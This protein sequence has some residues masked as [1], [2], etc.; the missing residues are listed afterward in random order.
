VTSPGL[1]ISG[2]TRQ[3]QNEPQTDRALCERDRNP[4]TLAEHEWQ[5]SQRGPS[6]GQ[7]T[8]RPGRGPKIERRK[9]SCALESKMENEVLCRCQSENARTRSGRWPLLLLKLGLENESAVDETNQHQLVR[10]L[11]WPLK[12]VKHICSARKKQDRQIQTERKYSD[13][14]PAQNQ[15]VK[16]DFFSLNSNQIHATTDVIA[17]V[18]SSFN[19]RNKN[20][21][22]ANS[23]KSRKWK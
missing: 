10:F 15:D 3:E 8:G 13:L 5:N 12:S 6:R 22:L 21:F 16:T 7:R 11:V 23:L 1:E 20:L 4:A 19:Y 14:Q 17:L 2:K 9:S 18:P